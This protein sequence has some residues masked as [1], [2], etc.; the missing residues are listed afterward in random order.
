M[1]EWYRKGDIDFDLPGRHEKC[2]DLVKTAV[3]FSEALIKKYH[4]E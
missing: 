4:L 1:S 3:E 2:T